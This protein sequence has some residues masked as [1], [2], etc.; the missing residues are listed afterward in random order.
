MPPEGGIENYQRRVGGH[1]TLTALNDQRFVQ[2]VW[3]IVASI[4][5]G[6]AAFVAPRRRP[7]LVVRERVRAQ[8]RAA[9][10]EREVNAE[11]RLA[12]SMPQ[13]SEQ[14]EPAMRLVATKP[15]AMTPVPT[16]GT[17]PR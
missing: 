17:V 15:C 4:G 2:K 12:C 8:L 6:P 14:H 1:K 16:A 3:P 13:R 9:W 10:A 7:D 5:A 11:Q